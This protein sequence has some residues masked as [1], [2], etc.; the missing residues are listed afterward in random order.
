VGFT[1]S[2][3][4]RSMHALERLDFERVAE[5]EPASQSLSALYGLPDARARV[6]ELALGDEIV[7][8]TEC[9]TQRG[10]AIP[11]DSRSDDPWFQHLAIVVR[12]MDGA[13]ERLFGARAGASPFKRLS[14]SPQTIPLSNPAAG[15]IRALYFRDPDDHNLELIWFPEGKGRASWQKASAKLFL[16]IDHSAIAVADGERGER[17][18]SALGFTVA[19][20]SLNFGAEQEALSGVRGARVAITGL[21]AAG[22]PGVEFLSYLAP[23]G[24]QSRLADSTPCDLWHWEITIAVANLETALRQLGASGATRVSTSIAN[25]AD[26]SLGYRRAVLVSDLDGHALRLVEP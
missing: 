24:R 15:G 23:R 12:D 6:A 11:P 18:Y 21:R 3:L 14:S 1:V 5:S 2:N 13:Y 26:S 10:R 4:E 25:F 16:G 8:L 20:R 19:G 22:G 17:V 9:T 7:E